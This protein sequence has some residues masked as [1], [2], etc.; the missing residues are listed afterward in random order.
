M[1][2]HQC[3]ACA[4]SIQQLMTILESY[5]C[6]STSQVAPL[7]GWRLRVQDHARSMPACKST[8]YFNLSAM[9]LMYMCMPWIRQRWNGQ[10]CGSAA[11]GPHS[12]RL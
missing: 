5:R 10:F 4:C 12:S 1:S 2:H 3:R 11:A 6:S 7:L 9:C 8:C